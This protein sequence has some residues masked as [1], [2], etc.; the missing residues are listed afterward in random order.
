MLT[1]RFYGR[2]TSECAE[3]VAAFE[4]AVLAVAAHR[5]LGDSLTRALEADPDLVAA[6]ALCGFGAIM[7]GRAEMQEKALEAR[8]AARKAAAS[9]EPLSAG[10][11]ALLD[12]LDSAVNG[13]LRQAAE[14]LESHLETEPEDFLAAKIAHALR[15][16]LGDRDAML[17]LTGDLARRAPESGAGYGFL[18]GCHAFGLEEAGDYAEA[19]AVGRRAVRIAPADSWG[20]HAVSHV[21]EMT[22]RVEEGCDWLNNSRPVWSRC[23]NFSF[24]M[25]WHLALLHLEIGD[26]DTV[27]RLYDEEIRP[28]QTDDFR[29]MSNAVSTLWRLEQEGLEVGDRWAALHEIAHRRRK[30]TTYIFASLHY[31]LTLIAS[32][33]MRGA[34]D[35]VHALRGR[36]SEPCDQGRVARYI[37][38]HL[39]EALIRMP[40]HCARTGPCLIEIA[41]R[42]PAIGGSHAQRD[43]FLRSLMAV[44]IRAQDYPSLRAI[45]ALRSELRHEDRFH[46]VII[47]RLDGG[48]QA[49]RVSP[50][51]LSEHAGLVRLM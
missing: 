40:G 49:L 41:R 44:A 45:D 31:L 25:A 21:F 28:V 23:N 17:R 15:F 27:L 24:H 12:S 39:A 38:L 47:Q 16:M 9:R 51:P 26:H 13:R 4:D 37:G 29:D 42:L 33:D 43:V 7:L 20:L 22:G 32:G 50:A 48:P 14:R 18:L 30:D 1:D 34:D 35:L 8:N 5:P 10:E 36:K 19:E 2:H 3:A 6:H 11:N 46:Q